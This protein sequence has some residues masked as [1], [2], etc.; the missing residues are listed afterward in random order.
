S[1]P[2]LPSLAR[3]PY[4]T[5]FRSSFGAPPNRF[6]R[7][8]RHFRGPTGPPRR[9]LSDTAAVSVLPRCVTNNSYNTPPRGVWCTLFRHF[10]PGSEDRKS[11]RL[12]SSHVSIS[13]PV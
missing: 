6:A 2:P 9:L 11:T 13:Y 1:F 7:R 4:T 12:N 3:F 8:I 10:P 5:R